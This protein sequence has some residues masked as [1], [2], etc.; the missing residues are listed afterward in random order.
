MKMKI[1]GLE[2]NVRSYLIVDN[3][4]YVYTYVYECICVYV[5]YVIFVV[6]ALFNTLECKYILKY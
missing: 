4:V 1:I 5:M 6:L 3:V 2:S